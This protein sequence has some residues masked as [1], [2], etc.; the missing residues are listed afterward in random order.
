M[1][2]EKAKRSR[3]YK[4]LN[5]ILVELF[6]ARVADPTPVCNRCGLPPE[7]GY[8]IDVKNNRKPICHKCFYAMDIQCEAS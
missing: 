4:A 1:S 3:L 6:G 5:K 7:T 2:D 8:Y